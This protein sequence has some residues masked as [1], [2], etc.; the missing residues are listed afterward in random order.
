ME[1]IMVFDKIKEVFTGGGK[2]NVADLAGQAGL[3]AYS[4]YLQGVTFPIG[5]DDLIIALQDNG[6]GEAI[7]QH[8]QSLSQDR[9]NSAEEVFKT[10]KH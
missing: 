2:S 4:K 5:K 10:L 3:G 7:I 6:A 9:F 8:V 1:H